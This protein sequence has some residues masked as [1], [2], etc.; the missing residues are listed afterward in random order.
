[1]AKKR[2]VASYSGGKD[3]I[4]AIHRAIRQGM[5][6]VCL[7]ITYNTGLDRSWFHGIPE[8]LLEAVQE[9]LGIPIHLIRT[10][11]PDY[12]ERFVEELKKQKQAGADCC[13]FGDI[14]IDGHLQWCTETCREAGMEAVFPLW[15][16]NRGDLVREFIAAGYTANIT[17]VDTL[18][19]SEAHLGCVLSEQELQAIEAEGADLCGENGEYHSFVSDGPLF[20]HPVAFSY[21]PLLRREHH[22]VFPLCKPDGIGP[23]AL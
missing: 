23:A 8:P 20:S 14:D 6:P 21:G 10:E 22:S 12:R 18:R 11:G 3:S 5:E 13:I 4:L 9:S 2:F 16:E 1:M 19:L 7:V 17:V 15:K